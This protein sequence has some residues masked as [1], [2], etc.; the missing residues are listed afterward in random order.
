MVV[1]GYTPKGIKGQSY[2]IHMGTCDCKDP[3]DMLL[4]RECLKSNISIVNAY[5]KLKQ[6]LASLRTHDKTAYTEGK[7]S[8]IKDVLEET[9]FKSHP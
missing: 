3:A 1:K 9:S 8:F 4:F 6:N 2:H 7:T 5:S